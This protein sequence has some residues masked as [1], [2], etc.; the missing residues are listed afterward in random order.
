[1]RVTTVSRLSAFWIGPIWAAATL[2]RR[3]T[4]F[5]GALLGCGTEACPWSWQYRSSDSSR[6]F[7]QRL[8]VTRRPLPLFLQPKLWLLGPATVEH[9]GTTGVKAT[10]AGRIDR[11]RHVA[12]QDDRRARR[13]GL[14]RRHGR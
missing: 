13:A 2:M 9:V 6:P 3:M 7:R 4:G 12:F 10:S 5:P 11:A 8:E 1:M 14:R